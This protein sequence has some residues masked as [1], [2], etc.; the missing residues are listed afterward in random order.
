MKNKIILLVLIALLLLFSP[1]V[2]AETYGDESGPAVE[3]VEVDGN[4]DAGKGSDNHKVENFSDGDTDIKEIPCGPGL[5]D[6]GN[7]YPDVTDNDTADVEYTVYNDGKSLSWQSLSQISE[8]VVKGGST[9][10]NIYYYFDDEGNYLGY[11]NDET[12]MWYDNGL[13][14]PTFTNPQGTVIEQDISHF[15][16]FTTCSA[17]PPPTNGNGNPPGPPD[18]PPGP[19]GP[20]NPPGPPTPPGTPSPPPAQTLVLPPETPLTVPEEGLLIVDPEAP[21]VTPSSGGSVLPMLSLGLLFISSG[22]LLRKFA[23]E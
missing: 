8:V 7:D 5:E 2:Y 20:P 3:P 18:P 23:A 4:P 6:L 12:G 11:W 16:F 21:M 1:A 17:A 19:P 15:S 14:A 9:G 13:M 10:A 22:V